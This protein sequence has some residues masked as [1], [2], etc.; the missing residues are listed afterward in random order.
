M[1]GVILEAT[2]A[3]RFFIDLAYALAARRTGQGHEDLPRVRAVLMEGGLFL[4]LGANWLRARK[5][6]RLHATEAA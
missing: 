6:R 1:F 5:R 2:G 4:L 3:G